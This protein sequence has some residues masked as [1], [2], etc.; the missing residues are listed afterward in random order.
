MTSQEFSN[1]TNPPR[2][3]ADGALNGALE[4]SQ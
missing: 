4:L 2:V 3:S 1:A